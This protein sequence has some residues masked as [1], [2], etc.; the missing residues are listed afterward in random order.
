MDFTKL[1]KELIKLWDCLSVDEKNRYNEL[2]NKRKNLSV[3]PKIHETSIPKKSFQYIFKTLKR[4]STSIN[5]EL[6][7]IKKN[8][9]EKPKVL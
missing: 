8:I 6:C 2:T 5:V 9:F 3:T 1:N 7:E 4:C